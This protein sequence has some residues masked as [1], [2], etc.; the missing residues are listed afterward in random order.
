MSP[1]DG[2]AKVSFI[3]PTWNAMSHG[4]SLNRTLASI[5]A[6]ELES[7]EIL[8]VDNLST[9]GTAAVSH[10]FGARVV[11]RSCGRSEA[12]NLG[13]TE[14]SGKFIVFLDSDHELEPGAVHAAIALADSTKLDAVFLKTRYLNEHPG[15]KVTE[16]FLNHE[17]RIRGGHMIPNFYRKRSIE[18]IIF[19]P[20]MD[21]G[22]DFV[23]YQEF[24]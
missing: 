16:S 23:F 5:A 13:L 9:D 11:E 3:I 10:D 24:S 21:L 6:Q 17:I 12:R 22:E 19:P 15:G 18:G 7:S 1:C 14:S 20:N 4:K 2:S 8:I